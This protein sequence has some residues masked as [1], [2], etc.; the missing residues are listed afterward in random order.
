[1]ILLLLLFLQ[2]WKYRRIHVVLPV[3]IFISSFFSVDLKMNSLTKVIGLNVF[4]FT[5]TLSILVI[6]MS[7]KNKKFLNPFQ[8]YF[9]LG[10]FLFYICISPLFLI[11]N[12]ILYF[13]LSMIF[14]ILLQFGLKK[15]VN[16]DSVPLA[17]FSSVFLVLVI[18][19]DIFLE[20]HK[21]TLI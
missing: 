10:D 8:N 17:G 1:M 3:L 21:M 14:S 15:I 12:Y 13:V 18:V 16:H 11:K 19:K 5:L 7:I 6:Y 2:D 20:T 9:G 4:F